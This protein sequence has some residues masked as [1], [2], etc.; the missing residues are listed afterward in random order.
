MWPW[1]LTLLK[2]LVFDVSWSNFETA[3]SQELLVW[4][5]W[6]R[7]KRINRILSYYM[8]LP[9][10]HTHAL[11]LGVS[12]P[13]SE[14]SYI[15]NETAD[16][17]VTKRMWVTHS[18]PCYRLR[19]MWPWWSG[20]MYQLVTGLTYDIGVPSTYLVLHRR[21]IKMP[22]QILQRRYE[23]IFKIGATKKWHNFPVLRDGILR[24]RD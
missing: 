9:F 24:L 11:G 14:I 5:M 10:D 2:T 19:L 21:S 16:W 18:W 6:N 20:R 7:R 13:E 3:V 8:T 15:R 1:P 17:H 22:L 23:N 12:R 4:L